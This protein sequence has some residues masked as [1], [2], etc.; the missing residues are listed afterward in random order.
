MT[1]IIW[2]RQDLRI[3][4]NPALL[5]AVDAGRPLVP[6][7]ILDERPGNPWKPGA[8]SRWWLAESLDSLGRDLARIGSRL[9][10]KRGDPSRILRALQPERVYWND[11]HEPWLHEQDEQLRAELR[12]AGTRVETF[13]ASTLFNPGDILAASGNPFRIYTAFARACEAPSAPRPAPARLPVPEA[14]PESDR[15]DLL[16]G[17]PEW[18]DHLHAAWSPGATAARSRL[19]AFNIDGYADTRNMPA[20]EGTSR[21]FAPSPSW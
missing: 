20:I 3:R 2:F 8:A 21:L 15:L 9:V 13:N 18:E 5:T 17:S 12:R 6:L 11:C 7:H 10:R 4:D 19:P 14:W 1:A 16:P